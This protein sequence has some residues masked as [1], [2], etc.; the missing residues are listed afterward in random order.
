MNNTLKQFEELAH[1]YQE[2]VEP[3]QD[4]WPDEWAAWE[5]GY[6][7]GISFARDFIKKLTEEKK[8]VSK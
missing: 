1:A 3:E 7:T 5:D 8:G 4:I 6:H 2:R